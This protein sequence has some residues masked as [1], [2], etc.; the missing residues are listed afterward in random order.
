MLYVLFVVGGLL[1]IF[2]GHFLNWPFVRNPWFRTLHLV[3]IG[4]VVVQSWL[5]KVCPLTIWEMALREKAGGVTYTGSFI[6]HWLGTL[7]YYQAPQWVF[8]LCYTLFGLLVLASWFWVRPRR[9]Q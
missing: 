4:I 7:L 3:A 9:F 8:V 1:L 6:S 5:E 2:V